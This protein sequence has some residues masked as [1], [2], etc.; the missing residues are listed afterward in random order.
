MTGTKHDSGKPRLELLPPHA[1]VALAEV[2]TKGAEKY[3]AH[4]YLGGMDHG[5][6]I[7]AALRHIYAYLRG[8][9]L[10]ELGTLH[11]SNAA[12]DLMMVIEYRSRGIGKDDRYK[13]SDQHD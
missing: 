5:R 2:M 8:E 13:G 3:G 9:D 1:I 12:V 11:L 6:L 4:N 7:G 10:D